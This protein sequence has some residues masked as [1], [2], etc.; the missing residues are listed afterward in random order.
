MSALP[1]VE[2]ITVAKRASRAGRRELA[3]Q[4]QRPAVR[5]A[6]AHAAGAAGEPD[7]TPDPA[8]PSNSDLIGRAPGS[9]SGCSP[10]GASPRTAANMSWTVSSVSPPRWACTS[11]CCAG[12]CRFRKARWRRPRKLI[13]DAVRT[14]IIS[15]CSSHTLRN[16]SA[17]RYAAVADHAV[18]V[19]GMQVLLCGAATRGA[20]GRWARRSCARPAHPSAI[21]SARTPCPS[22]WRCCRARRVLLSPD[23]GPV[24]MAT[25]VGYAGHRPV[26]G[27][28][29]G[30]HRSL[31][32]P[33][34]VRECLSSGGR[35]LSR[36]PRR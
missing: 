12:M 32:V 34:L 21:A 8:P 17:E 33:H 25:M 14:L 22:C 3:A 29:S 20:S 30:P 23:S 6:A 19:H 2:F 31:P 15:P 27:H 26:C 28:Q 4:A 36:P 1:D 9:C 24:H 7:R 10:T 18:R 35:A 5:C 11:G 16:W 13:P